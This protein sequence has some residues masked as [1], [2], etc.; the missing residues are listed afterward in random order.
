[1]YCGCMYFAVKDVIYIESIAMETT[2]HSIYCCTTMSLPTTWNILGLHV[3][4]SIFFSGF[5]Q[6]WISRQIFVTVTNTRFHRNFS[7]RSH[8][9]TH[10]QMDMMKPAV[11]FYDYANA[12]NEWFITQMCLWHNKYLILWASVYILALVVWHANQTLFL[13]HFIL[14][15][16]A[17]LAVP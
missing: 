8:A 1:L 12:P 16:V 4:F 3:K 9:D 13:C 2:M 17:C 11:A 6:I 5:N 14:L 10:G 15:S 7:T